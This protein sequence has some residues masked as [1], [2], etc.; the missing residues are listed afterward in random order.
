MVHA[1]RT[2]IPAGV[3]G[4]AGDGA[5]RRGHKCIGEIDT[6]RSKF[7][8]VWCLQFGNDLMTGVA[9]L[10]PPLVIGYENKKIWPDGLCVVCSLPFAAYEC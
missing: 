3:Y 8:K 6:F 4:C 5:D 7:I 1:V 10:I 2:H 9:Y